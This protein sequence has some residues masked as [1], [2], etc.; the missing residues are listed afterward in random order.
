MKKLFLC[1]FLLVLPTGLWAAEIESP[2][3]EL[4]GNQREYYIRIFN[5][6]MDNIKDDKPYHWKSGT[7]EGDIRVSKEYTSKSKSLCR[8]FTET[9]VI[10]NQAE[11]SA[12]VAC[13]R[14][15]NSGWCRLK[16]EDAHTCAFEAPQNLTDQLMEDADGVVNKGNEIIRD[17]QGWWNR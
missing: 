16:N 4:K 10:A 15:G 3:D 13:K 9:F 6:V 8:N 14:N 11:R 17:T 1:L 12:G 5:Y 2:A 7:G